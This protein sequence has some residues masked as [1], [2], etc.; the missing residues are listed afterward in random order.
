MVPVLLLLLFANGEPAKACTA[1]EY[2]QFDFWLGSW[3]VHN[4]K[5][6]LVGHNDVVAVQDGCLVTE[7]WKSGRGH[8][9]GQSINYF[10]SRDKRWHQLYFDNSGNMGNY[11][12]IAG[13]FENGR[14]VL[15]SAPDQKPLTR[16][17]WYV[18]EPGKV[19][20]WAE[21]SKDG[22][23]TWATTWDSVYVKTKGP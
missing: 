3:E 8:E 6:D 19:R 16:W 4:P 18:L 5:G 10:D 7:S 22:G 2:R 15:L 13:V 21:A 1:P 12:P 17:T 9:S 11:P 14:M 23:K 20:Q